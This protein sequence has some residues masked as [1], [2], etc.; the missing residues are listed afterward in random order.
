MQRSRARG[1]TQPGSHPLRRRSAGRLTPESRLHCIG[2]GSSPG[3]Q[4]ARNRRQHS[5]F[6]AGSP[7]VLW[8]RLRPC[9][10]SVP[11]ARPGSALDQEGPDAT[12]GADRVA[13]TELGR[14]QGTYVSGHQPADAA[15]VRASG[16]CGAD[17]E[18]GHAAVVLERNRRH[19]L[20][21]HVCH[22]RIEQ[23]VQR[24]TV[25]LRRQVVVDL[26]PYRLHFR[27]DV[28]LRLNRHRLAAY[29]SVAV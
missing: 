19:L 28:G 2:N 25:V 5:P 22:P 15:Y 24:S 1:S 3:F 13:G 23:A 4:D 7:C 18:L 29:C 20:A 12:N 17:V 26:G 8:L 21:E 27:K 9:G 11:S 16:G 6:F 14:H 10:R